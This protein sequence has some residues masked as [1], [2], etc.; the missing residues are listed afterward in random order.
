MYTEIKGWTLADKIDD[1]QYAMLLEEA[2]R[3]LAPYAD[4][5]GK[6]SFSMPAHIVSVS[7]K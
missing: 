1:R 6:V 2:K 7:K 5:E 4:A 3:E